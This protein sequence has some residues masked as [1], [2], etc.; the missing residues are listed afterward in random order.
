MLYALRLPGAGRDL[1][2]RKI[3]FLLR[4]SDHTIAAK[5][6]KFKVTKFII[7][8]WSNPILLQ[9]KNT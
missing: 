5:Q 9:S 7:K 6:I 3:T 8:V 4:D 1:P 2:K